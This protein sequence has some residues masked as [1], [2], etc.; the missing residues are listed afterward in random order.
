MGSSVRLVQ[1][2]PTP[3][4]CNNPSFSFVYLLRPHPTSSRPAHPG[5]L[6]PSN[7]TKGGGERTLTK[8]SHSQLAMADEEQQRRLIIGR[9]DGEEEEADEGAR[10]LA[11]ASDTTSLTYS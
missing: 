10:S 8:F 9:H 1:M 5:R 3:K 11:G 4:Y 6:A 7:E 2:C